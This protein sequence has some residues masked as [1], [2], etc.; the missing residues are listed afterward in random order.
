[1]NELE[2]FDLDAEDVSQVMWESTLST[3]Y[4]GTVFDSCGSTC[5]C[6][7]SETLNCDH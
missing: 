1:M 6:D 2:V 3:I 7:C 5:D 4:D